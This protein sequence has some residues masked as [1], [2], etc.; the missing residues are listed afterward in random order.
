MGDGKTGCSMISRLLGYVRDRRQAVAAEGEIAMNINRMP[1]SHTAG[2]P[3]AHSGKRK[4]KLCS[5][6]IGA[7]VVLTLTHLLQ[8]FADVF[9]SSAEL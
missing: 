6:A 3:Q 4:N 8:A 1:L 9:S 7:T 2:S 5:A